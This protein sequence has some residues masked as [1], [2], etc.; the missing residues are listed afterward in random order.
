MCPPGHILARQYHSLAQRAQVIGGLVPANLSG[1]LRLAAFR[2]G[3]AFFLAT[4]FFAAFRLGAAFFLATF[5]F[6]AAFLLGA[7]FLFATA[8]FLGAAF[9]LATAFFLALAFG[10]VAILVIAPGASYF[11]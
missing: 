3:A 7:A 11:F 8:F 6:A 9:F 2:L 5:F 1:Y 10:F 4:F